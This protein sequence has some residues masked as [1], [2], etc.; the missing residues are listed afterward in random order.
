MVRAWCGCM[1]PSWALTICERVSLSRGLK[2]RGGRKGIYDPESLRALRAYRGLDLSFPTPSDGK[3]HLSHLLNMQIPRAHSWNSDSTGLGWGPGTCVL[4]KLSYR[5][6]AQCGGKIETPRE[7][8]ISTSVMGRI[9]FLSFASWNG[10]MYPYP[11][12]S[13]SAGFIC[14]G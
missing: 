5:S 4:E 3:K 9:G 12:P 8:V 14:C 2:Q 7:A 11:L 10:I 13:H 6:D 1:V